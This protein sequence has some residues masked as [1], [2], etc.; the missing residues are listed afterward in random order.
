MVYNP[1]PTA[2]KVRLSAILV[3]D[4]TPL[5]L[6]AIQQKF[7]LGANLSSPF[8]DEQLFIEDRRDWSSKSH[9]DIK[10]AY[11]DTSPLLVIDSR[12]PSDGGIWYIERF[13]DSDSVDDGEAENTN[14]L[15]KLCM[16]L[17][18][19]VISYANYSIGNTDIREDMDQVDIAYPTPEHFD[20][21]E[22]FRSGFDYVGDRYLG[23]AWITATPEEMDESTDEDDLKNFMP[24]PDIVYRLKESIARDNGIKCRWTIGGDA[25]DVTLP[26]GSV[27]TFPKGSKVLQVEYDPE[28]V[29]PV[30]E[31]PEGSL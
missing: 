5:Q 25:E 23:P 22:V 26:D 20:Q 31:R 9:A 4:L 7:G 3:A 15:F 11:P 6:D 30:Y 24:K 1:D 12:T 18:D 2:Q 21:D 13:A 8:P 19:V 17:E 14:T 29:T 27:K 28:T 10:R 16:G